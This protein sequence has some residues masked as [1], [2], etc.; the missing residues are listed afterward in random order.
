MELDALREAWLRQSTAADSARTV[1][2]DVAATM[3]RGRAMARRVRRRDWLETGACVVLLPFLVMTLLQD[4][5]R[6]VRAGALVTAVACVL[7]PIRLRMARRAAP[8]VGLSLLETLR[9]ELD[10]IAGQERLLRTSLWWY[11]LPLLLGF[12]LMILGFPGSPLRKAVVIGAG[13]ALH[14]V[15][16]RVNW[17]AGQ[18]AFASRRREVDDLLT[19]LTALERDAGSEGR[20]TLENR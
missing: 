8:V 12:V 20:S 9:H 15:L 11:F 17:T 18:G 16:A 13:V 7:I 14:G 10:Y 19:S 5:S 3:E 1:D 2:Q 4:D 6:L